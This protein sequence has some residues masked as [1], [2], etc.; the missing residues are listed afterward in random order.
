MMRI[1]KTIEIIVLTALIPFPMIPKIICYDIVFHLRKTTKY[2]SFVS[3]LGVV[4]WQK[5]RVC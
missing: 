5:E 1:L 4:E 2:S 3:V